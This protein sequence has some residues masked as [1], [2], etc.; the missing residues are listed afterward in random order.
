LTGSAL[1]TERKLTDA[2]AA[3][4]RALEL[5]P[6]LGLA[7]DGLG[8]VF[9]DAGRFADARPAFERALEMDPDSARATF[10]LALVRDRGGELEAAAAGYKRAL[11][12][13]PFDA[14]ITEH[15]A[16]VER[17]YGVQLGMAGRTAEARDAIQ[18]ALNLRPD[19][20]EAWVDLCLLLL[21]LGDRDGAAR[22][23]D[24]GRERGAGADRVAF[25]AD[26]L[27]RQR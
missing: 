8:L 21:D 17:K 10:H 19:D 9:Y 26:A 14:E 2:E 23:L 15:L 24:R 5:D 3:Y 6:R 16:Q 1:I 27:A 4:R 7:W 18:R 12:L 11:S 13:S 20:G 22:A 25:A